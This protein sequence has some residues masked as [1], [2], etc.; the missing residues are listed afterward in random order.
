MRDDAETKLAETAYCVE[1]DDF[2]H[3]ELWA[4]HHKAT[5]WVQHPMGY[6]EL[7]GKLARM[8]VFLHMHWATLHGRLVMFYEATSQ[9]VDHRMVDRYLTRH[10]PAFRD[11]KRTNALNF[12]LCLG[13]IEPRRCSRKV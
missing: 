3:L 9:V 5:G 2:A 13:E 10:C 4:K 8:P 12:H 1:A 11:G 7:V 6:G